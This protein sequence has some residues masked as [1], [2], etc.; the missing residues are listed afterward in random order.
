MLAGIQNWANENAGLAGIVFVVIIIGA[1]AWLWSTLGGG[2]PTI[3]VGDVWYY[4]PATGEYFPGLSTEF[5][6]ISGPGGGMSYRA[7]FYD[8]GSCSDATEPETEPAGFLGYYMTFGEQGAAEIRRL[9]AIADAP[10]SGGGPERIA[11]E[12]AKGE[13][14][15]LTIT[16]K[17]FSL[18]GENW[19]LAAETGMN[20]PSFLDSE[21]RERC[22]DK[23]DLILC[24]P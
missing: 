2:N 13:L 24:K 3:R 22:R 10:V 23:G 11:Q 18:D 16:F 1:G 20:S 17:Q 14:M 21:I 12:Q 8:C 9:K 19:E 4:E 6:P 7:F 15:S 5:P